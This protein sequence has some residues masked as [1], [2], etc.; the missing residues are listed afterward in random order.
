M[1]FDAFLALVSDGAHDFLDVLD[2]L[3]R[4]VLLVH[5]LL[6]SHDVVD[7]LHDSA[8]L[9]CNTN[10]LCDCVGIVNTHSNQV[11]NLIEPLPIF[12]INIAFLLVDELDHTIGVSLVFTIHRSNHKV[13]HIT[14]LWLIVH[15]TVEVWLF[16]SIV[17]DE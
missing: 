17:A 2:Q 8:E 7:L 9:E 14:H 6:L 11:C 16:L 15:R 1:S 5:H 10:C 13:V 3:I 12:V 4:W